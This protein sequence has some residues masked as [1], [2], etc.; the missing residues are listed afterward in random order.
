ML[1]AT[2]RGWIVVCLAAI[3]LSP[4][5]WGQSDNPKPEEK[6]PERVVPPQGGR[7]AIPVMPESARRADLRIAEA[8]DSPTTLDAV[9][10]PL[11]DV[12]DQLKD[13]HGIEIQLDKRN[14]ENVGIPTD[15]P[16][17]RKFDGITLRSALR[18]I[19][20]DL[21][22]AYVV[23]D[24]VL[25]ITT[26]DPDLPDEFDW[27]L[28][29]FGEFEPEPKDLPIT[30]MKI[31][32]PRKQD[33]PFETGFTGDRDVV[34]ETSDAVVLE[35][36]RTFLYNPMRK[37]MSYGGACGSWCAVGKIVVTTSE[38]SFTIIVTNVGFMLGTEVTDEAR[39]YSWGLAK[40]VD[41]VLFEQTGRH[42]PKEL[43]G[44]MSGELIIQGHQEVYNRLRAA[45]R[46][47]DTGVE[48]RT[49]AGRRTGADRD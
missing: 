41:D 49:H 15:T 2:Q 40:Y 38:R 32:L 8:L 22:L 46:E 19:L 21:K 25:L 45:S 6:T 26:E 18:L 12:V 42:I 23:Q 28:L 10:C 11:Q 29:G 1:R 37:S 13:Q 31:V 39:F 43:F 14:L 36:I 16:I 47:K 7:L 35:A 34:C 5:A 3:L 30:H 17:T 48:T 4:S 20:R 24:E 33:T 27:A 44:S 9:E